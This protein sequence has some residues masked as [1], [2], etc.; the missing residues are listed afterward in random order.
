MIVYI[1]ALKN[2]VFCDI[3]INGVDDMG[4]IDSAIDALRFKETLFFKENSDLQLK[5]DALDKLNPIFVIVDSNP[6]Y[7]PPNKIYLICV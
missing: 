3:I 5:Y 7:Y 1:I 4:L 6:L 2:I